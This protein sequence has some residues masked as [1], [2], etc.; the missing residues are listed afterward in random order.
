MDAKLLCFIAEISR[1]CYYQWLKRADEPEKD[2][3]DYLLIKEM[4]DKGKAKW[5]FRTIQMNLS[6][7][8][9]HKK[10]FKAHLE[11]DKVQNKKLEE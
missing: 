1:S 6:E 9:N 5:G 2:F 7:K 11:E 3:S 10:M 4:F 8:M